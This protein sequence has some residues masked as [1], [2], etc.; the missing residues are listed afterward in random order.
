MWVQY[1]TP[2]LAAGYFISAVVLFPLVVGI[3]ANTDRFT[4]PDK[5]LP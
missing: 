3:D 2:Q 4:Y 5:L 1:N